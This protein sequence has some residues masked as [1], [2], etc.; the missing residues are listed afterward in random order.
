MAFFF[1]QRT[2]KL[3]YFPSPP[4]FS[5]QKKKLLLVFKTFI[6]KGINDRVVG[7]WRDGR[8][9]GKGTR[10]LLKEEKKYKLKGEKRKRDLK[11]K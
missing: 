3:S 5:T 8:E 11:M 10:S 6:S 7:M 4:F 1:L 2:G 9:K